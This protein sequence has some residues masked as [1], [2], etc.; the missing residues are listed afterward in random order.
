MIQELADLDRSIIDSFLKAGARDFI[1]IQQGLNRI[2]RV[3]DRSEL[4][5]LL[6]DIFR[7][8]HTLKG[9]AR[10]LKFS[11]LG[12]PAHEL[13]QNLEQ[14]RTAVV[15]EEL[16]NELPSNSDLSSAQGRLKTLRTHFLEYSNLAQRVLG[17]EDDFRRSI[18]LEAGNLLTQTEISIH[19]LTSSSQTDDTA[20]EAARVTHRFKA[21]LRSL[22]SLKGNIRSVGKNGDTD[23]VHQLEND[24]ET[25]KKNG[26][27]EASKKQILA[28]LETLAKNLKPL[29]LS[30]LG[31][32][33]R[34]D[35]VRLAVKAESILVEMRQS[36]VQVQM[37][38]QLA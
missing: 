4:K 29:I 6:D 36:L 15:K 13:E 30:A 21:V 24:L 37:W 33:E 31:P 1:E 20:G 11:Y 23:I 32:L 27:A 18:L 14:L 7:K 19:R 38:L 35:L 28:S 16:W 25:L 8:A 5:L 9:N 17:L 26:L 22:H 34:D 12:S 2:S 10:T 3:T